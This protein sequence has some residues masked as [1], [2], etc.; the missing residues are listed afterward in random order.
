MPRRPRDINQLAHAIL[1]EVTGETA[2]VKPQPLTGKKADSQKGGKRGGKG[3]MAGLSEAQRKELARDA[4]RAR[5]QKKAP[6]KKA[7]A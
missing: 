6:A 4:A 1:A 5:W 7:G 2:P 3:R